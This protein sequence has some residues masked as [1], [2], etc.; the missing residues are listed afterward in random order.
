MPYTQKEQGL[1]DYDCSVQI[2]EDGN[3]MP[4]P[5][6]PVL[7]EVQNMNY[8][9]FNTPDVLI[10]NAT[11]EVVYLIIL[12][13]YDDLAIEEVP[14][15][16]VGGDDGQTAQTARTSRAAAKRRRRHRCG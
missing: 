13:E 3:S 12:D 5:E 8:L 6:M 11:D 1:E 7:L 2:D 10:E 9:Q 15:V 14:I 16:M 4:V